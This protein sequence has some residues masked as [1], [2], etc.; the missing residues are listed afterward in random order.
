MFWQENNTEKVFEV[1]DDIVDVLF[2]VDCKRLPVDHAY[3]LSSALQQAVPWIAEADSGVAVHTVHV[4]GS[5]NGW[6]RPQ[7]GTA[8]H[9]ILSKRTKL[10]IRVP[11]ERT[12][13][14]AKELGG[15]T[16]DVS[17]CALRIGTAKLRP[18]SK[19]RTL[20]A[21]YVVDPAEGASSRKSTRESEAALGP[22]APAANTGT[23]DTEDLFLQ[24]A[25][26]VLGKLGIRVRKA[27]CGKTM[28]LTVP[29]GVLHTRSL[30]LADLSPEESIRLQQWG[31]GPHREMGCGIFI[32]HKGI[33]AVGKA[34]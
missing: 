16:L 34:T 26:Q 1:P 14:L 13:V 18:L 15:K 5:Q 28:P 12:E 33:D 21:R 19:E 8:Q 30:M 22:A 17:G 9:L 31:L 24:W 25:V 20:F 27:L 4:A 23:D 29:S 6:E 10:I 32:P 2:S 11:K 7:H 3:A